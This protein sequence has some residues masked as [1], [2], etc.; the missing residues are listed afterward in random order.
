[1]YYYDPFSVV[2][3]I[4]LSFGPP[5]PQT[6]GNRF[7]ILFYNFAVITNMSLSLVTGFC[8][9]T[10]VVTILIGMRLYPILLCAY[11]SVGY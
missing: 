6:L 10:P 9:K 7:F 2:P 4:F 11:S 3:F 1:M 5:P 8:T